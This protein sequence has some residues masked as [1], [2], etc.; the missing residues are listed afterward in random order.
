MDKLG[1][2]LEQGILTIRNLD[3]KI[4]NDIYSYNLI[5]LNKIN[6]KLSNY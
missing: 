2:V 6:T 5:L 3:R 4:Y 1:P